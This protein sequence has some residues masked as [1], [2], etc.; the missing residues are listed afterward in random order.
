MY[1]TPT[2]LFPLD[3]L[4]LEHVVGHFLRVPVDPG[5]E[6]HLP[7]QHRL[8][9]SAL[10]DAGQRQLG[11]FLHR[12][13]HVSGVEAPLVDQQV[14]LFGRIWNELWKGSKMRL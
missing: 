1:H 8:R 6:Q 2:H 13:E 3:L 14:R 7:A 11:V 5:T 9:I 12:D 4:Q 10:A